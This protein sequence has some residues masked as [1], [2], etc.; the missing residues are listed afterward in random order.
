MDFVDDFGN[1][2]DKYSYIG[3]HKGIVVFFCLFFF[4]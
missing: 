4:A 1:L 2:V 3:E